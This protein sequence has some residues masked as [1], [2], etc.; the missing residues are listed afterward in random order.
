[1]TLSE[2]AALRL[3]NQ[4]L[5]H[6]NFSS[7]AD[8]VRWFGAI[9]AQD[10]QA[11]LYAIGLR[12]STATAESV[13]QAIAERSIIRSWP[14]RGT[15][16]FMPAEDAKWM[17]TLLAPAQNAKATN[18]YRKAGLTPEIIS[19]AG[20][21]LTKVL[22]GKQ[23]TRPELYEALNTAGIETS[24]YNGEQRGMHILGYWAREALICIAPRKGKQQTFALFAE[25]V[26]LGNDL[27]GDAALAELAKRYFQSHG[28][29][30][31]KDFAWWTGVTLT[32]AKRCVMGISSEFQKTIV[33]GVEL[34]FAEPQ[35]K[36]PQTPRAFLL[37]PF[38]EYT[39]AYA[40]RSAAVES[41][42]LRQA[43]YG[44]GPNI[45]LDGRI[46]GTWRRTFKKDTVYIETD[47]FYALNS[48]QKAE[49]TAA[50]E[51]YGQ[52]V[53]AKVILDKI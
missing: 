47:L 42:L 46:A 2:I 48:D 10:L 3:Y 5:T 14:M 25:W 45:I 13:E 27:Q 37:P 11:S 32:D 1:M 33:N 49:V 43:L 16:H 17:I 8:V 39:V 12:L 18:H 38:D 7:P 31:L 22:Q 9:Q 44:I 15:I 6:K 28:P 53:G 52:F 19:K 40:D 30:S 35:D 20:N 34:W 50:A 36:L 4:Q 21:V 23:L 29:A 41:A 24:A 26:P 51:R